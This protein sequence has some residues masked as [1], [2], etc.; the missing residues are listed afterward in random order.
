MS[1]DAG[2]SPSAFGG[3]PMYTDTENTG[4]PM[5]PE[6]TRREP[7]TETDARRFREETVL[8]HRLPE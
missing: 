8:S 7:E 3:Q 2:G 4:A 6:S 5:V 1:N